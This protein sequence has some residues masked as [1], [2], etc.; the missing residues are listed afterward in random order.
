MPGYDLGSA[1]AA[2]SWTPEQGHEETSGGSLADGHLA[3]EMGGPT[4]APMQALEEEVR[5]RPAS[6]SGASGCYSVY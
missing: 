5:R 1:A 6:F 4:S 2:P 3:L